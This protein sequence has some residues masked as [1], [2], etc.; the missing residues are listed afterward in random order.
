MAD[1]AHILNICISY[2][3]GKGKVRGF[4]FGVY[5][6]YRSNFENVQKLGQMGRDLVYA[7]Y[8]LNLR[9]PVNISQMAKAMGFKFSTYK[10]CKE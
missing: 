7:T 8:N 4:N 5:V 2:I 9:T 6:N 1:D 10:D 3:S